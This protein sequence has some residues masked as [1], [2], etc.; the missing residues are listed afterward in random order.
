MPERDDVERSVK[1]PVR[2]Q[3]AD[4]D[5]VATT[6]RVVTGGGTD[7]GSGD[8]EMGP[9]EIQEVCVTCPDIQETA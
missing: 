5:V 9:G 8:V 4:Q 7:I 1:E 6:S 3:W 2:G